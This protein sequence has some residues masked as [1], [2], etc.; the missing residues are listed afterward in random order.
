M[1]MIIWLLGKF[2]DLSLEVL[3]LLNAPGLCSMGMDKGLRIDFTL[4]LKKPHVQEVFVL[5]SVDSFVLLFLGFE[6]D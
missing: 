2:E 4:D 1:R 5:H 6:N 3:L